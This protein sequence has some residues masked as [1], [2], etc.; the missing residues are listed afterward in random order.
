MFHDAANFARSCPKCSVAT[1]AGR[2]NTL[3]LQPIPVS[4]PF[5][6]LSIDA[7]VKKRE[8]KAMTSNTQSKKSTTRRYTYY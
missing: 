7:M 5:Q 6:V 4:H 1:K 2:Q 8:L 3:Q